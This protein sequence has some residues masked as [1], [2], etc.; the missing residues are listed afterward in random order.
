VAHHTPCATRMA[1]DHGG[2]AANL[3]CP[4][5]TASTPCCW[6]APGWRSLASCSRCCSCPG[7]HRGQA[8]AR[9]RRAPRTRAGSPRGRPGN[10]RDGR[11]SPG[12]PPPFPH[13]ARELAIAPDAGPPHSCRP[14]G[15]SLPHLSVSDAIPARGPLARTGHP[16][17]RAAGELTRAQAVTLRASLS[18]AW[19][20]AAAPA[21]RRCRAAHAVTTASGHPNVQA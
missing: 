7:G 17:Q 21:W 2:Q 19:R 13:R 4:S 18:R 16:G 3:R 6:S 10:G 14:A 15:P 1:G 11:G 12:C 5:C 8:A 9:D 20:T